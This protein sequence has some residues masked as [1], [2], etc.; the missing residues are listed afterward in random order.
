MGNF[1]DIFCKVGASLTW[2]FY[3]FVKILESSLWILFAAACAAFVYA[4]FC[5]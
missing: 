1:I 2:V 4:L 5:F 3:I